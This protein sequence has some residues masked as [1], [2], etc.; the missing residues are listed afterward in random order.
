MTNFIIWPIKFNDQYIYRYIY[1][2]I[3][4]KYYINSGFFLEWRDSNPHPRGIGVRG[5]L[6]DRPYIVIHLFSLS[7]YI[8]HIQY[9]PSLYETSLCFFDW[10]IDI[11]KWFQNLSETLF[12]SVILVVLF[13]LQMI[14]KK[15]FDWTGMCH[16]IYICIY[17]YIHHRSSTT[18][19]K[20]RWLLEKTLYDTW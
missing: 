10:N 9:S 18:Y 5:L 20:Y 16:V 6:P 4:L 17:E 15:R 3:Y 14:I 13:I 8:S 2:D 19:Y 7:L 1:I 12:I 11:F